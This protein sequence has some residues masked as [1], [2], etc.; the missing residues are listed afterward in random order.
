MRLIRQMGLMVLLVAGCGRPAME[1]ASFPVDMSNAEVF[2]DEL[3]AR[4]NIGNSTAFVLQC[5]SRHEW[6]YVCVA[7]DKVVVRRPKRDN[8]IGSFEV[9]RM[10][11]TV[12]TRTGTDTHGRTR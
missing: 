5:L 3:D 10:V 4:R 9:R 6:D 7:G 1:Y 8:E 2:V 12:P 11:T